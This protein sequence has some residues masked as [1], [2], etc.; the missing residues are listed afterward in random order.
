MGIWVCRI[1][2][3]FIRPNERVHL[4][5]VSSN[6]PEII[7]A[8]SFEKVQNLKK[9]TLNFQLKKENYFRWI[10]RNDIG[11]NLLVLVS[12]NRQNFFLGF[13]LKK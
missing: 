4:A 11:K 1:F 7:F 5:R 2:V 8:T 12:F 13:F 6:F 10:S 9:P 3:S